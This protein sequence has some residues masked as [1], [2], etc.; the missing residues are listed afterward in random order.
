MPLNESL[1]SDS[2]VWLFGRTLDDIRLVPDPADRSAA[3][4]VRDEGTRGAPGT[5]ERRS[6]PGSFVLA[7]LLTESAGFA[8]IYAFS[9]QNEIF[10]LA[11]PALFVVNGDGERI[12]KRVGVTGAARFDHYVAMDL[13]VW[14]YDRADFS[15]RLDVM[16]GTFDRILIDYELGEDAIV[17]FT[18][19]GADFGRPSPGGGRGARRR[20]RRWRSDDE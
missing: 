4:N 11:K 10:D 1:L 16:T 18:R 3:Y 9:Y 8:R 7:Q 5:G 13:R 2:T 20:G 19:G 15:V 6:R 17:D 14:A 12:R